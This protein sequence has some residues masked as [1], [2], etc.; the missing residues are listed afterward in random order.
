MARGGVAGQG[1]RGGT[2]GIDGDQQGGATFA[3]VANQN[4]GIG[5]AHTSADTKLHIVDEDTTN[6]ATTDVLTLGHRVSGGVGAAGIGCGVVFENENS[7]GSATET[8]KVRAVLTNAGLATAVGALRIAVTNGASMPAEGSEQFRLTGA[9]CFG[10]NTGTDTLSNRLTIKSGAIEFSGTPTFSGAGDGIAG[11]GGVVTVIAAGAQAGQFTSAGAGHGV[12]RGST[13][14]GGS[15]TLVS[16]SHATA[17]RVYLGAAQATYFDETAT[18]AHSTCIYG[19][20]NIMAGDGSASIGTNAGGGAGLMINVGG[21]F[22]RSCIY[23]AGA[24]YVGDVDSAGIDLILRAN[25]GVNAL[26]F[27]AGAVTVLDAYN[28]ALA[29]TTGT[30][31]GTATG[32]KI[33]FWDATPVVQ[34]V[35]ATGAAH[36]VDDVI[37][38]L[39]TL[40]LC[41]QS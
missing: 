28:I 13:A 20:T 25:T 9:G 22:K 21:T 4:V 31:I 3:L 17:G 8:V 35:L 1:L 27:A 29:T 37:A 12:F 14:S 38:L 2:A 24:L 15:L 5:I 6:N 32:Q 36:V 39:Q 33:G 23:S 40:G 16:S 18:A 41:K 26:T 10:I 11:G 7:A 30:K 19:K 34:Q